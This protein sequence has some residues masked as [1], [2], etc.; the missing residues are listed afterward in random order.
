MDR[1]RGDSAHHALRG[2]DPG[3]SVEITVARDGEVREFTVE[4]EEMR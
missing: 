4:L 3:A 2:Y 1:S